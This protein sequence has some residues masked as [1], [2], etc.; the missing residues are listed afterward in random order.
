L[1]ASSYKALGV[2]QSF[3]YDQKKLIKW[4]KNKENLGF[5]RHALLATMCALSS[6]VLA[7]C[8]SFAGQWSAVISLVGFALF[9]VLYIRADFKIA[10]KVDTA[11]TPRFKRLFIVTLFVYAVIC[12]IIVTLL[13]FAD[14]LWKYPLFTALRY[15]PLSVLPLLI[16]PIICLSNLLCK[17]YEEPKNKAYV[18]SATEK[19]SKSKIK[20]V[21]ITGSFAKTTVKNLLFAMLQKKY[22]VLTT[23]RSHN[24]PMGIALAANKNNLDEYDFFIAEM[25]ARNKG[26]IKE[27]CEICPPDYSIITGVCPQHLQSFESVENIISTKAEIIAPTKEKCFIAEP[28]F[29]LFSDFAG[30]KVIINNPSSVVASQNGTEFCL[31]LGENKVQ[32]KTKL[33]GEHT[34]T[35]FAL[36]AAVAFELGV[37]IEDIIGAIEEADYIE[38]RLQLIKSNEVNILDDGYNANV[39][40]AEAALGVLNLFDGRKIAVTPGIVELGVLE[41][42]ENRLLGEKLCNLD[43]VILVGQTLVVAVKE[44]YISAGGDEQKLKIAPNLSAAQ[45]Y[46]KAYIKPGDTVLFLNDLPDT[47][48]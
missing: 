31:Q 10:L 46:L 1:G 25:G 21:G 7:L 5:S 41:K 45:E 6:A 14:Y 3:R 9:A 13:N 23:P 16:Y 18:R 37:S 30:E 35:N 47:Y 42:Q 15:F 39:K 24:T 20:V 40:G 33:L 8:F 48:L 4:A 43:L 19:L 2:L 38:H 26:D 11:A 36:A 44:G 22:K 32:V 12:Y 29:N 28:Y 34:A 27:L 17:I